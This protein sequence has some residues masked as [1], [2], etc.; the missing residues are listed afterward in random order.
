MAVMLSQ[1]EVEAGLG[2][3]GFKEAIPIIDITFF[4]SM[5]REKQLPF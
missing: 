2:K 4:T 3:K 5:K 1:N